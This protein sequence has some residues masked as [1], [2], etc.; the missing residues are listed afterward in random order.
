MEEATYG[1]I[2]GLYERIPDCKLAMHS[3]C[4]NEVPKIMIDDIG[5]RHNGGSIKL[6]DSKT[7]AITALEICV[8]TQIV[9][10]RS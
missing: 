7:V 8:F 5:S 10:D 2:R 4:F 9:H 1:C 6:V 3:N